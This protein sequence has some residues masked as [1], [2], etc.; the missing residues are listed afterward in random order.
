MFSLLFV[1][2]FVSLLTRLVKK[3]WTEIS[4]NLWVDWYGPGT[5]RLDFGTDRI[6]VWIVDT[7]SIFPFFQ[8]GDRQFLDFG[9]YYSKSCGPI[10]MKFL[11]LHGRTL[12]QGTIDYTL[13][14]LRI[15]DPECLDYNFNVQIH[16]TIFHSQ[17]DTTVVNEY[18]VFDILRL[19]GRRATEILVPSWLTAGFIFLNS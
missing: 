2:L 4:W 12:T 10:F 5:N 1:C 9:Q 3:L 19:Y 8:H 13:W 14:L 16:I 15:S 17:G 18:N 7:G 11:S 6:R